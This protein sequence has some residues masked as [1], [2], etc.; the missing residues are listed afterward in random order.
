[1]Q[2]KLRYKDIFEYFRLGLATGLLEI[3]Q[4]IAWADREIAGSIVANH[5]VIQLALSSQSPYS[6]LI[7]LL[8]TFE[9]I[10]NPRISNMMLLA[11]AQWRCESST[12]S[13]VSIVQGI[14]LLQAEPHVEKEVR[15]QLS[16]L[17]AKLL[18]F[19]Q[20]IVS[21]ADLHHLLEEFLSPYKEYRPVIEELGDIQTS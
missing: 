8:N 15:V 13:T 19:N 20:S 12:M 11:L 10:A 6:Q 14:C 18:E 2:N 21:G 1:M 3:S 9:G 16:S 17:N 5:E 7:G 4:V